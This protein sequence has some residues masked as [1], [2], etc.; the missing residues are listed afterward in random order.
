[1]VTPRRRPGQASFSSGNMKRLIEARRANRLAEEARMLAQEEEGRTIDPQTQIAVDAQR[2]L[3]ESRGDQPPTP[4][5]NPGFWGRL[6]RGTMNVLEKVNI[7]GEVSASF[8]RGAF[9]P[10]IRERAKEIREET[11]EEGL[12]DYLSASRKAYKEKDLPLWQTLPLEIIADPLTWVPIAAPLKAAKAAI[13]A[14]KGAKI[15]DIA[16]SNRIITSHK[17]ISKAV[18]ESLESVASGKFARFTNKTNRFTGGALKWIVGKGSRKAVANPKDPFEYGE[19]LLRS[20]EAKAEPAIATA[21]ARLSTATSRA[22]E[23]FK[24]GDDAVLTVT[25]KSAAPGKA[26]TEEKLWTDIFETAF[27]KDLKATAKKLKKTKIVMQAGKPKTVGDVMQLNASD[28][29]KIAKYNMTDEQLEVIKRVRASLDEVDEMYDE[30]GINIK[31]LYG[32]DDL[33]KGLAYNPRTVVFRGIAEALTYNNAKRGIG[34]MPSSFKNRK[35]TTEMQQQ[36]MD[37][38]DDGLIQYDKT[39]TGTLGAYYRGAYKVLRE[40]EFANYLK[41]NGGNRIKYTGN[42]NE[43]AR[44]SRLLKT[45]RTKDGKAVIRKSTVEKIK[46]AFP[47]LAKIIEKGSTETG[48]SYRFEDIA[49]A[50]SK[51]ADEALKETGLPIFRTKELR[52]P[53]EFKNLFFKNEKDARRVS[54][55]LGTADSEGFMKLADASAESLGEVGDILRIGKTGFDF[56]FHLIQGL[57]LLGAAVFNP[58]LLRV[59]GKSVVNGFKSFAHPKQL[60]TFIAQ[61]V[62]MLDESI[63]LGLEVGYK[64]SDMYAGASGQI[65]KQFSRIKGMSKLKEQTLSRFE[66]QFIHSGDVLRIEGYKALRASALRGAG[67]DATSE[68]GQKALRELVEFLNKSTGSLNSLELGLRPT[69][70]AL[71]RAFVF[72][73]PRYTRACLALIKDAMVSGGVQGQQARRALYG[74]A[75]LGMG[76]YITISSLLDQEPDLDPTSST[77]MSIKVNDDTLGIGSFWRSFASFIVRQG[78]HALTPEDIMEQ[79]RGSPLVSWLRGRGSPISGM[80]WDIF[81]GRDFLGRPLETPADIGKHL[82][83]G[84]L[85]FWAE[86]A[87]IADPYRIGGAGTIS[88]VFGMRTR[89]RNV[90]ERRQS[91]RDELSQK[92]YNKQWNNLNDLQRNSLKKKYEEDLSVLNQTARDLAN[93]T[94]TDLQ[95]QVENYYSERDKYKERWLETVNEGID[96]LESRVMT[97][98]VFRKRML[99][100]ANSEK[101]VDIDRLNERKETGDLADVDEYFTT[102]AERYSDDERPEDI[103]VQEYFDTILD[104]ELWDEP[105]GYDYRKKEEAEQKFINKWGTETF[106][107]VQQVLRSGQDLPPIVNEYYTARQKFEWFFE[108]SERAVLEAQPNV[109][110]A[111]NFRTAWIESKK[112]GKEKQFEE[113]YPEIKKI[114]QKI[115]RVKRILREQNKG[116]DGFLVRWGY[117]DNFA[118]PDNKDDYETWQQSGALDPSVYDNGLS[119]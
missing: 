12:I 105:L 71:E 118:H 69:Q 7:P 72:F 77:F 109:I 66:S 55:L 26:V 115:S 111:E 20:K 24:I 51:Q 58:K 29:Q 5:D 80:G 18:E 46:K 95:E 61:N 84:M 68:A 100:E 34:S 25:V 35:Y 78:D 17:E 9:D 10:S 76:T 27:S 94:G 88:E 59:W 33:G 8:I 21:V 108:Q 15:A 106:Q 2:S 50:F 114:N 75:G 49:K 6:G 3:Q 113:A 90:W 48:K 42:A 110:E 30:V 11:P 64:A 89:P 65:A 101:R 19:L 82:G 37:A 54:K 112:Q 38:I 91:L 41:A 116:L 60:E 40:T 45:L 36:L 23:V 99:A 86:Q 87:M 16:E 32:E 70:R 39:V 28:L 53:V 44:V 43:R 117:Y 81:T 83:R 22:D 56:G 73:S 79:Q 63:P 119:F 93:R 4:L 1:M 13:T 104:N 14:K 92:D 97:P 31:K 57:P 96:L 74:M 47:N 62:D 85:P 52:P 67:G 98:G 102:I 103:A 107:Y